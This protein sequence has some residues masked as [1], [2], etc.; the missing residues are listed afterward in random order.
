[1]KN[2]ASLFSLEALRELE[3]QLG[4]KIDDN[5]D[6]TSDELEELYDK[7]TDEFPYGYGE[8]GEPLYMGKVFEGIIDVLANILYE[9]E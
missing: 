5:K 2:L 3:K 7:I 6:Y 1:M 9:E 8:D 4:I